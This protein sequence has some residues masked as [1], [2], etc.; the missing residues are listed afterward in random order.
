MFLEPFPLG[1]MIPWQT[2]ARIIFSVLVSQDDHS[3]V[4]MNKWI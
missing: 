3:S 1:Q 2:F 4:D